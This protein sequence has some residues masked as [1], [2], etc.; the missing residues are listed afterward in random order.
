MIGIR[1]SSNDR[2]CIFGAP[3][4]IILSHEGVDESVELDLDHRSAAAQSQDVQPS[5]FSSRDGRRHPARLDAAVYDSQGRL[6]S[7]APRGDTI[8]WPF[9]GVRPQRSVH[10]RR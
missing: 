10:S 7:A 1:K 5:I 3:W 4:L 6:C 8:D 2:A 9:S